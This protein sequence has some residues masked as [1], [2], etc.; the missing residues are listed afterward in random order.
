MAVHWKETG[1]PHLHEGYWFITGSKDAT[2][3]I[4][5]GLQ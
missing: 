1:L 5:S 2:N 4:S 3:T